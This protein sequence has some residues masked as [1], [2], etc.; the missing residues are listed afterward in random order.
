M[1]LDDARQGFPCSFLFSNRGD[2]VAMKIYFTTIKNCFHDSF[3]KP[4]TFMSDMDDTFYNAW[5]GVIGPVE[6]RLFCSWHV[7][8]AWRKNLGKIKSKEKQAII[9]KKIKIIM[10]ET[11]LATFNAMINNL[12]I[13][14]RSDPECLEFFGYFEAYAKKSTTWAY[15]Y[16]KQCGIN[17]NMNL[18]NMH[19]VL[20]HIYFCGKK[21]KKMDKA[22]I[23]LMK[24][25]RDKLFDR[26]IVPTT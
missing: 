8:R 24:F 21:V 22:I 1:V 18:E 10:H 7:D 12:L 3:I 11:D 4:K 14:L 25:I 2:I 16:R 26:L 19:K 13:E 15:C 6:N 17:T 23:V 9:Y 5:T 20:K